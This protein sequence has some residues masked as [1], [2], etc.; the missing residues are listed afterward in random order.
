MRLR[1]ALALL[2]LLALGCGGPKV[3]SV[4]GRVTFDDRPLAGA[5]VIFQP[6]ASAGEM[7][8]GSGSYAVTDADGRYT[9]RVVDGDQ[10]GAYVG[11]H[12]VEISVRDGGADGE[13]DRP[14]KAAPKVV[15]PPRYNR[16]TE[17]TWEVRP[18]GTTQANFDLRSH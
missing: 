17:L 6:I 13:I 12:R 5:H 7:N 18:E 1:F 11:Q 4:S 15:I 9:L 16:N 8:P 14:V 10:P 3:A 2:P